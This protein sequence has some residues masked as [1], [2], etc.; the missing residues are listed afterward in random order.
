MLH[1]ISQQDLTTPSSLI[2][3]WMFELSGNQFKILLAICR[4]TLCINKPKNEISVS[5]IA[6]ITGMSR[7]SVSQNVNH[8]IETGLINREKKFTNRGFQYAIEF[9]LTEKAI[10]P[11]EKY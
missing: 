2:D 3:W 8:L 1:K 9:E 5:E 6:N 10:N 11:Q 4:K 7:V